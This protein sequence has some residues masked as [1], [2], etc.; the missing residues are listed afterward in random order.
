MLAA[1]GQLKKIDFEMEPNAGECVPMFG[2]SAQMYAKI[3]LKRC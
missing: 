2:A 1:E 3:S